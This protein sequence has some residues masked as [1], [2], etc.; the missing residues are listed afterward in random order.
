MAEERNQRNLFEG[1]GPT[2]DRR[3][4]DR[5]KNGRRKS[6]KPSK[7]VELLKALVVVVVTVAFVK[8]FDL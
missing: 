1:Q 5:R 8:L 4:G 7:L 2:Q 6:D 3:V